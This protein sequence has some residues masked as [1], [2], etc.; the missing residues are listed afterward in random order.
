MI[1]DKKTYTSVKGHE[2]EVSCQVIVNDS[3]DFVGE[4]AKAK[5][6]GEGFV[7]CYNVG[8]HLRVLAGPGYG[9]TSLNSGRI[10]GF[11]CAIGEL[12]IVATGGCFELGLNVRRGFVF[13]LRIPFLGRF[14]CLL[15]VAGLGFRYFITRSS[16]RFGHPLRKPFFNAFM[17]LDIVGLQS[18]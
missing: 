2:W 14:M 17:R 11:T 4:G 16:L 18:D 5:H 7:I 15:A 3:C 9:G 6:V 10:G 8:A 12:G 13:V 1:Q